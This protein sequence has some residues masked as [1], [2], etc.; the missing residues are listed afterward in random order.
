[1]N[2]IERDRANKYFKTI[3]NIMKKSAEVQGLPNCCNNPR[4]IEIGADIWPE[5]NDK[6][7]PDEPTDVCHEIQCQCSSC[8]RYIF[9]HGYSSGKKEWVI[10][11]TDKEISDS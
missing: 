2:Q 4:P 11:K 8:G 9:H 5:Y 6:N 3:G 7:N 1:M 10:G